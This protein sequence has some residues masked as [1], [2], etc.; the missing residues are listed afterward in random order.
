MNLSENDWCEIKILAGTLFRE[1]ASV[2]KPSK[3]ISRLFSPES[4]QSRTEEWQ[5]QF[6]KIATSHYVNEL[7]NIHTKSV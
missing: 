7:R 1:Y 5:K 2:V 4:I 3:I 6:L